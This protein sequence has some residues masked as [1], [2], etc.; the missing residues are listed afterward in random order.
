MP[1]TA[2]APPPNE[3]IEGRAADASPELTPEQEE[4]LRLRAELQRLVEDG[5]ITD[6]EAKE[7]WAAASEKLDPDGGRDDVVI[8]PTPEPLP[9]PLEEELRH[10]AKIC[11]SRWKT[12]Y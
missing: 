9:D 3:Q 5:K 10:C 7:R 12:V 2:T 11:L 1:A 6:A 4:L 8:L